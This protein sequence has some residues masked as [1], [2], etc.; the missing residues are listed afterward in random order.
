[1]L[2]LVLASRKIPLRE[3]KLKTDGYIGRDRGRRKVVV[4]SC[5]WI[6]VICITSLNHKQFPKEGPVI[7]QSQSSLKRH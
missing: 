6:T 1:M 2:N 3:K 7:V 4:N 5:S